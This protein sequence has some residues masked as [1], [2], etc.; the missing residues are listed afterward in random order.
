MATLTATTT[1]CTSDITS[2]KRQVPVYRS[3]SSLSGVATNAQVSMRLRSGAS[4]S[5]TFQC[6]VYLFKTFNHSS[7]GTTHCNNRKT[8]AGVYDYDAWYQHPNNGTYYF[9]TSY[10]GNILAQKTEPI[11]LASKTNK[12]I[13][14]SDFTL[15]DYG[16]TL[17]NWAGDVC[18]GIVCNSS[19]LQWA[20]GGTT[21]LTLTYAT[22]TI[23][24]GINN[25][26]VNCEVY[27]GVDGS[28]KK[29]I[30]YYATDNVFK[31]LG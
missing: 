20:Q 29:V 28:F 12:T 8:S 9:S 7:Y 10:I 27:Y 31:P 23:R 13:T 15:T 17:S 19:D 4:S 21:T 25:T 6:T 14:I 30:P 1:Y 3:V 2:A 24:Y 16:K 11:T 26:F 22:G 5:T 18:I